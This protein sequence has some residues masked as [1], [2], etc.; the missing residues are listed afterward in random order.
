MKRLLLLL[1]LSASFSAQ[2][3]QWIKLSSP[4]GGDTYFYDKSK[5]YIS[6]DEITYWKK[7][8]FLSPQETK[9]GLAASGLYRERIHCAEHTL[10]MISY[11][12]YDGNGGV[13]DYVP[14]HEAPATPIIPDTIGDIFERSLCALVTQH[15]TEE[16][17]KQEEEKQRKDEEEKS[18]LDAQKQSQN[19]PAPAKA[20]PMPAPSV[21][22]TVPVPPPA[23][24]PAQMPAPTPPGPIAPKKN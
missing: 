22:N 14:D 6:G 24:T 8:I 10:K 11:L 19:C 12:L 17:K 4:A 9:K 7:I 1:A 2:G 16:K 21:E 13:I 5:L 20:A 3:A 18:K 23:P 15:Q